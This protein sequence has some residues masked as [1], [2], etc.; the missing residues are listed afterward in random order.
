M[1]NGSP[2]TLDNI[3]S[4]LYVRTGDSVMI[5]G[6]IIQGETPKKVVLRDIGPSLAAAGVSEALDDPILELWNSEGELLASKT[7]GIRVA[8]TWL[9]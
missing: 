8:T 9:R 2:V 1:P 6:F 3:S 7:T 4:R 5:G